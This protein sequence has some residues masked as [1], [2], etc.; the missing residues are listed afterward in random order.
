MAIAALGFILSN[1]QI[2]TLEGTQIFGQEGQG[3]LGQGTALMHDGKFRH[4]SDR[5]LLL[6]RSSD[7][8]M[9]PC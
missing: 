3:S 9:M 8:K 6:G 2:T 5:S 1:V 4:D 7:P